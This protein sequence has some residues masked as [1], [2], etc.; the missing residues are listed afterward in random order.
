MADQRSDALLQ[1]FFWGKITPPPHLHLSFTL[2]PPAL[3][4]GCVAKPGAAGTLR[5]RWWP[6][7]LP[8][9]IA[10]EPM[11]LQ[12]LGKGQ[13]AQP[14][15]HQQLWPSPGCSHEA[16]GDVTA[17]SSE[18][19]PRVSP[20]GGVC[21]LSACPLPVWAPYQAR[22]TPGSPSSRHRGC[23]AAGFIPQPQAPWD[24][25]CPTAA[26]SPPCLL[27][28]SSAPVTVF[29]GQQKQLNP[30]LLLGSERTRLTS[31]H[32]SPPAS[33]PSPSL[34]VD[35]LSRGPPGGQNAPRGAGTGGDA[36]T[37]ALFGVPPQHPN[38]AGNAK[39][40]ILS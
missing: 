40:Q 4:P 21:V 23:L 5:H 33:L 8:S 39:G 27:S 37:P 18:D 14:R 7:G 17:R 9:S 26:S 11:A 31:Q 36:A 32:S 15:A 28:C 16:H 10:P 3:L 1:C 2:L 24:P 25:R 34:L 13:A 12:D 29:P 6:P 35:G 22:A 30:N 38:R 20:A 19:V